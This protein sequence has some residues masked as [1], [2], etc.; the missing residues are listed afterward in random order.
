VGPRVANDVLILEAGP[1]LL[2][3]KVTENFRV[4]PRKGNLNAPFG[5]IPWAPN[6]H[7]PGYLDFDADVG[8]IPGTLRVAGGTSRH[9]TGVAWRFL[10]EEMRLR[11]LFGIGRDWLFDYDTLEPFYTAA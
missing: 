8:W 7:T 4:S 9:W 10:P 1:E 5:D 11:S 2:D 3:W 6:S